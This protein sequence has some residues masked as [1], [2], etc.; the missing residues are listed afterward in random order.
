M[1][2]TISITLNNQSFIIEEDAYN[3]LSE[4][5]ENIKTHCGAG[6]D[7]A[8]VIADIENSMAEKLKSNLNSYKEVVNLQDVESL[9]EIMGTTEDFDRE[10]GGNSTD[11]SESK[12]EPKVAR[13][14]Y[15][16]AD[17]AIIGGVAAGIGNYFDI[18]PVLIRVIF[19]A[20]VFAGGSGVLIYI[21]LWIAMP[22]A[23]T[24]HQKL[25]MKGRAPTLA[26]FKELAKT[27]K[28]IQENL[29]KN[30]SIEKIINFPIIVIKA[31]FSAVKNIWKKTWPVIKF[32]FGLGLTVFSFIGLG[33][34]GVGGLLV[35]L[36]SGSAYEFYFIPFS[37]ITKG[38]PYTWMIITG[39]L[40]FAI[41]AAL[42]FVCGLSIL[43]RKNILNFAVG[44]ILLMLWMGSGIFFCASS[45]RY[46]P[47]V[48]N[49]FY[50]Y[51]PILS[52]EKKLDLK[53]IK[54]IEISGNHL[55]VFVT[56]S[57]TTPTI[58]SG[59]Q[60]D[61]DYVTVERQNNKLIIKELEENKD[62]LCF[63]CQLHTV[64]LETAT[65]SKIK[66]TTKDGATLTDEG[67][68]KEIE[69]EEEIEEIIV[70]ESE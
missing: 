50:N 65:S 24:A 59:R 27:G 32:I 33:I 16:D 43:F 42:A 35:L 44:L 61:L 64:S 30:S 5:L 66:I 46:F 57:T 25:E 56:K 3:K 20:L 9:I 60:I 51:P 1:E 62:K 55:A 2:K 15:R 40:S 23:K 6:A 69:P 58:L 19:F 63:N 37:E 39:F 52:V 68:P 67:A 41:P 14:L 26:A 12:E 36:Y 48:Q 38:I 28:K 17:N 4:Y 13:K 47:E 8:E 49:K 29:K 70:E 54:E 34:I 10:I 53:D 7:A 18:D 45:L 11:N 21:L 31:L 22:E